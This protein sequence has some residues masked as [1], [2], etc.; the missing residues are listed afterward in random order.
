M[1]NPPFSEIASSGLYLHLLLIS[2][3]RLGGEGGG[4]KGSMIITVR[5]G[6]GLLNP[7][8]SEIASSGL[9]LHLLLIFDTYVEGGG[10]NILWYLQ[11]VYLIDNHV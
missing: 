7:P 2:D 6:G 11:D 4:N 1:L 5:G 9:Y 8:F 10:E 3:T